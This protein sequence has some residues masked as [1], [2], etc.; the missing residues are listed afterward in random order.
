LS[1]GLTAKTIIE[2]VKYL[3]NAGLITRSENQIILNNETDSAQSPASTPAST[4]APVSTND[5][6]P[7]RR[8]NVFSVESVKKSEK[9][10]HNVFSDAIE[11]KIGRMRI[12]S[13]FNHSSRKT[14][15]TPPKQAA[16]SSNDS[17]PVAKPTAAPVQQSLFAAMGAVY[18]NNAGSKPAV[19]AKPALIP[20]HPVVPAG[21][22]TEFH[23]RIDEIFTHDRINYALLRDVCVNAKYDDFEHFILNSHKSDAFGSQLGFTLNDTLKAVFK[24]IKKNWDEHKL[25]FILSLVSKLCDK[26]IN[27]VPGLYISMIQRFAESGVREHIELIDEI[28]IDEEKQKEVEIS[29]MNMAHTRQIIDS[30][31]TDAIQAQRDEQERQQIVDTYREQ[32][33]QLYADATAQAVGECRF[34]FPTKFDS[35]GRDRTETKNT[36]T[37]RRTHIIFALKL[38][39]I[40]SHAKP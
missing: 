16:T 24:T 27:N 34:L 18:A 7:N 38:R 4:P 28:K 31:Q 5:S 9:N 23:K 25:Y 15:P 36:W 2:R 35:E 1:V 3:I 32:Y 30:V 26:S 8:K 13:N 10:Q 6:T 12:V 33:S 17:K 19:N 37:E 21:V 29:N 39:A 22:K 40:L 20:P 14:A 11:K